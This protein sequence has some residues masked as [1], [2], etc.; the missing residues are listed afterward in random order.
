MGKLLKRNQFLSQYQSEYIIEALANEVNWGDTLL[1][2]MINSM[3]RKFEIML[4]FRDIDK[5][6]KR[7]QA[8]F[9]KLSDYVKVKKTENIEVKLFYIQISIILGILQ[10]KAEESTERDV[11]IKQ[12]EDAIKEVK[13]ITPPT[14]ECEKDKQEVLSK[15]E[16][17]K[18]QLE[19]ESEVGKDDDSSV[20]TGKNPKPGAPGSPNLALNPAKP[21]LAL[22]K[23]IE[24]LPKSLDV[25]KLSKDEAKL[26]L[27]K[28]I[29]AIKNSESY[30]IKYKNELKN[31]AIS[32]EVHRLESDEISELKRKYREATL[33]SHPDRNKDEDAE[34]IFEKVKE[35]YEK[36]DLKTLSKILDNLNKIKDIKNKK[37]NLKKIHDELNNKIK[38]LTAGERTDQKSLTVGSEKDIKQIPGEKEKEQTKEEMSSTSMLLALI[39]YWCVILDDKKLSHQYPWVA[40]LFSRSWLQSDFVDL[41]FYF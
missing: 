21:T 31:T 32:T 24:E 3:M 40:P 8:E 39:G 15:L 41:K 37:S 19:S 11:M 25:A 4:D 18:R 12:T 27:P 22:T 34:S 9:D 36:K 30:L 6:I 35:A 28:Y 26:Y 29:A 20:D 7:L 16:E 14:I 38:S 1:G 10:K 5:C 33:L 17:F 2:R 13:S 23:G